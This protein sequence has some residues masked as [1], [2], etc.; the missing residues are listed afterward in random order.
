MI[1][2]FLGDRLKIEREKKKYLLRIINSLKNTR[3]KQK[4]SHK[5]NCLGLSH[6]V[7]KQ[8][9]KGFQLLLSRIKL[10]IQK[11]KRTIGDCKHEICIYKRI[12][13]LGIETEGKIYKIK[14]INKVRYI[15]YLELVVDE[16]KSKKI[17]TIGE[18]ERN[19]FK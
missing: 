13:E 10:N 11:K 17:E 4:C 19:Y 2:R 14:L 12:I 3:R 8:N 1:P 7:N 15:V 6:N 18:R 9:K 16:P 5:L